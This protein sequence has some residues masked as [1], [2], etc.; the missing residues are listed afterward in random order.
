[1]LRSI[2]RVLLLQLVE[3]LAKAVNVLY[4]QCPLVVGGLEF[5]LALGDDGVP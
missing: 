3:L 1:M 5:L 2:F 4:S